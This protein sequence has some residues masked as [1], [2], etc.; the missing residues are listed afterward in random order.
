[1]NKS[2]MNVLYKKF[3]CSLL[4][5]TIVAS[6]R[7]KGIISYNLQSRQNGQN[8]AHRAYNKQ[9]CDASSWNRCLTTNIDLTLLK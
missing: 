8:V 5:A 6:L 2:S 4:N 1:M 7:F 9:S 3:H